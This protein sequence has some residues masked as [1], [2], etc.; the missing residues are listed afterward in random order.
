MK[1]DYF[2]K[3]VDRNVTFYHI[4]YHLRSVAG[5]YFQFSETQPTKIKGA[6]L[7]GSFRYSFMSINCALCAA[8]TGPSLL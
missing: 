5:N 2:N 7:L 6:H 8:A 4:Q 1:I 3:V